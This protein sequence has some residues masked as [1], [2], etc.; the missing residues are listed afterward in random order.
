MRQALLLHVLF[1]VLMCALGLLRVRYYRRQRKAFGLHFANRGKTLNEIRQIAAMIALLVM[2]IHTINPKILSW[3]EFPLP[4]VIRW[5]G[6]AAGVLAVV[7]LAEASQ[8]AVDAVAATNPLPLRTD[9]AYAVVRHPLDAAIAFAAV[10]LTLL[11][12]NWIVGLIAG[13]MAA[14]ALL[15]RSRRDEHQLRIAHGGAYERYAARTPRF[16]PRLRRMGMDEEALR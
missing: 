9:G 7:L 14:H 3:T 5:I 16:I 6:G 15:I 4:Y 10:A 11:S 12:A 2:I 1:I 13:A 8:A